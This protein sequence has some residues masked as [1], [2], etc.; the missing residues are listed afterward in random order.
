ME[1]ENG[2]MIDRPVFGFAGSSGIRSNALMRLFSSLPREAR[3]FTHSLTPTAGK[4]CTARAAPETADQS[5][6]AIAQHARIELSDR[7][8]ERI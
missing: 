7:A 5:V 4:R 1:N 3:S 6:S 2:A 8:I